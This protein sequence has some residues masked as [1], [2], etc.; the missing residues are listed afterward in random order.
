MNRRTL[1]KHC[2]HNQNETPFAGSLGARLWRV[3]FFLSAALFSGCHSDGTP[4]R[5][6]TTAPSGPPA[7]P[8]AD[9][10]DEDLRDKDV[11][12]DDTAS[13]AKAGDTPATPLVK[14]SLEG[15]PLDTKPLAVEANAVAPRV[16][17]IVTAT[18]PSF[19]QGVDDQSTLSCSLAQGTKVE[20]TSEPAAE[21][22][23]PESAPDAVVVTF[24]A[25]PGC[26]L[27]RGLFIRS[28]W[29]GF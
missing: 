12:D 2:R 17:R 8:S 26:P 5:A 29:S 10:R 16:L 15:S 1:M 28:H 23:T 6:P 3:A 11:R 9:T 21:T 24:V 4:N 27:T 7:R 20:V 14:T 18:Q 25:P 22:S 19:T 13:R